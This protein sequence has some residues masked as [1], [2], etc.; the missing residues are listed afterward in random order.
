VSIS[1]RLWNVERGEVVPVVLDIR[2]FG[3]DEAHLAKD[4]D[5]FVP[6]L[7]QWMQAAFWLWANRQRNVDSLIGEARFQFGS[8]QASLAGLQCFGDLVL[9]RIKRLAGSAALVR[10]QLAQRLHLVGD[11]ALP[12]QRRDTDVVK[13]RG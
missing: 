9:Q 6:G 10:R 7:H 4:R 2:A 11:D 3:D 12:P 1:W 13:G 5:Q 8:F